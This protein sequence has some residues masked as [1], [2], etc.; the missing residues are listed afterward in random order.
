M[1]VEGD[2]WD[3]VITDQRHLYCVCVCVCV[4]SKR[5]TV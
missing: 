5:E 2:A 1:P 4:H 3:M